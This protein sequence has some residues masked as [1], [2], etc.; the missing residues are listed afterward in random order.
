MP[1]FDQA[2]QRPADMSDSIS[3]EERALETTPKGALAV[4]GA[5]LARF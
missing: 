1:R 2:S 3:E 4:A 5:A